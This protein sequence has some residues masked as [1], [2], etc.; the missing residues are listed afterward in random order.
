MRINFQVF[1]EHA[2]FRVSNYLVV[3]VNTT[4]K[5]HEVAKYKKRISRYSLSV[6]KKWC[7]KI[8]QIRIFPFQRFSL[9]VS[10]FRDAKL[11]FCNLVKSPNFIL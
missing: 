5:V 10:K 7:D 8:A 11:A 6:V 2:H 9:E 4:N 3:L 1:L